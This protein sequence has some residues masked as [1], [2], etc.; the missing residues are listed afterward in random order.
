MASKNFRQNDFEQKQLFYQN[1]LKL[2]LKH[3][4]SE[5]KKKGGAYGALAKSNILKL[6]NE[7]YPN[8]KQREGLMV[9][10][11]NQISL[12]YDV[13]MGHIQNGGQN[14]IFP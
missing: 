3:N 2:H 7:I 1:A 9:H 8:L 14:S 5:F 12:K 4:L 10:W 6:W 13:S 11:L